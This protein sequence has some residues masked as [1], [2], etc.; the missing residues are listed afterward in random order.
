MSCCKLQAKLP[1][2]HEHRCGCGKGTPNATIKQRQKRQNKEC[3]TEYKAGK[4]MDRLRSRRQRKFLAKC[5]KRVWVGRSRVGGWVV[6]DPQEPPSP[7]GAELL[8][9]RTLG[10]DAAAPFGVGSCGCSERSLVP[11][12]HTLTH[13][14]TFG[15]TSRHQL[16]R[17]SGCPDLI[18]WTIKQKMCLTPR[19]A[20]LR[21]EGTQ[22][23]ARHIVQQLQRPGLGSVGQYSGTVQGV[24]W[25]SGTL[26]TAVKATSYWL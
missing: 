5:L 26:N 9:K 4:Y 20:F 21:E 19:G 3:S 15:V 2:S 12:S 24:G 22:R 16:G 11:H 7:W 23:H 14:R 13:T 25:C 1:P 8:K 10:V 17:Q 18:W 6:W